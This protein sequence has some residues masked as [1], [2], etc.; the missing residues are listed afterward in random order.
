MKIKD[1]GR[2]WMWW[3]LAVLV[4]AQLYFVQELLAAFAIFVLGFAAIASV[5]GA[6]YLGQKAWEA[7]VVRVATSSH[8]V[9]QAA[10]RGVS[11]VEDLVARRPVRA[12]R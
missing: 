10:K 5:V 11:A 8:P 12:T 4:A 1:G 7:G 9:V 6:L 2:K 3:F